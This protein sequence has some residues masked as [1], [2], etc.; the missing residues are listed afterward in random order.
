MLSDKGRLAEALEEYHA[1]VAIVEKLSSA[2][3]SVQVHQ[4]DLLTM[5]RKIGDILKSQ[6]LVSEALESYQKALAISEKFVAQDSIDVEIAVQL[7]LCYYSAAIV[8]PRTD[9][10]STEKAR[11]LL[12]KG[13][14]I[15]L[16]V[17]Q[18]GALPAEDQRYLHDIEAALRAF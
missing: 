1:S 17:Q 9:D 11:S 18:K 2:D 7:A 14:E 13:H 3:P 5:W 6:G 8:L 12:E 10:A 16:R 4:A 15:L